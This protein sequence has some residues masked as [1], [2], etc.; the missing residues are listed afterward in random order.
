MKPIEEKKAPKDYH[1]PKLQDYGNIQKITARNVG[2]RGS[3]NVGM[4]SKT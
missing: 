3:D 1:A 2:R 4:S